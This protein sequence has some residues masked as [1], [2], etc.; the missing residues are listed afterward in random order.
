MFEGRLTSP[1]VIKGLMARHGFR[2]DRMLGQNFLVD[3]NLLQKIATAA[4][5]GPRDLV[6]E[7]G[8]GFGTL[9]QALLPRAGRLV[10]IELDRRLCP[11]LRETLGDASNLKI[12]F[13]DVLKLQ[14]DE[15]LDQEEK[16]L[17]SQEQ[18]GDAVAVEKGGPPGSSLKS[19]PKRKA[20]ANLPY[21]ITT[22]VITRLLEPRLDLDRILIMVQWEVAQRLIA[23]PGTSEYGALTV[24]VNFS[25]HPSLVT[26]VPRTAFF[27]QPEVDSAA[28]LLK[29][30]PPP[31]GVDASLFSRV[32]R[33]AFAQR[34]KT[35]ARA[36]AGG[37]GLDK[38]LLEERLLRVGID[39]K[40][41]G[42][43]LSREEF[44]SLTG[45][46]ED[47]LER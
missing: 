36:L 39:W 11:V 37:L 42:E 25:T 5:L 10:A 43:T 2:F 40:R 20:V 3:H 35:L 9:T 23:R 15:I 26:R 16:V 18:G 46:L 44:V 1:S 7:V 31:A 14:L 41:R 30:L 45:A 34:R 13:G 12:I 19:A 21:Y 8:P 33:A 24:F 17:A 38:P 27:P 29:T 47:L 6:L 4:E 22:P 28:I 32:V